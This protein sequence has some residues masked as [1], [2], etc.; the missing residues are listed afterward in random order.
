MALTGS[1]RTIW[2]MA[3]VA[4]V[5]LAAGLGLS[6]MIHSPAE[7]AAEA[8]P[9]AAGPIS[10]PVEMR[11]LSN[12]VVLRGD[13]I[14]EDPV[15]VTL[16]TGDIG[17]P[18]VVTGHV[19]EVGATIDAGS[20]VL[21]VTGRPVILLP[22]DLPVYRSL[23]AGVSGP[24]V[25]QL[26]AAL[27][28][29]GIDP[30]NPASDVYDAAT[31]AGVQA[32]YA[33]VGYPAPSAGDEATAAVD[34][35]QSAVRA[36]Q[37]QVAAAQRDLAAARTGTPQSQRVA[38]QA[39]VDTAQAEL[40]AA[41]AACV[42]AASPDCDPVAVVAAQ[43]NLATKTA[44]LAEANAAPDT[45]SAQAAVT[46]AQRA[47]TDAQADL[48]DAK[49]DTLTPLPSSEVIYLSAT[50]RRIDT[51]DVHRGSTV[52]G[53]AVMSV[54][55]A[56]LQIAGSVADADAAL[57]TE[58][59]PVTITLPSD[60]E[61]PGTVQSVGAPPPAGTQAPDAGRTRVVVVPTTL[62]EEQRAELQG[63]NV[64][65]TIPV[66]ST[67]GEVL[68]VPTAALTAGPGGEARVELLADDET[69]TLVTV[70]TGLAAGGFVE[71]TATEGALA[72][73][74][75]VV[76]GIAPTDAGAGDEATDEATSGSAG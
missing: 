64:R 49:K 31:A 20:V 39:D 34:G 37:D 21:E 57:I 65:M 62:T 74:D 35:A 38:A 61:V 14:Y 15:S 70:D 23:R 28:A 46:A 72:A 75:R 5:S 63:A 7:V 12:D 55:G 68:A 66:G 18:A 17:G 4:V 27:V 53:T 1:T 2:T 51:V 19:P 13:A 43:G 71:V 56:A 33:R 47:L 3:A 22:G 50:P 42:D 73:G 48:V 36:A 69:T 32:L 54:S 10:V 59:S 25:V 44:A 6:Q 60:A 9:P 52:A 76:V 40:D 45:G 16:E 11:A 58:G 67:D 41:R 29:L 26:K 30:G 24:D 8:A